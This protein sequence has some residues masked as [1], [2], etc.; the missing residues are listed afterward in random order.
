MLEAVAGLLLLLLVLVEL[1][2]WRARQR[3]AGW[4]VLLPAA[5]LVAESRG[6]RRVVQRLA[7]PL[8]RLRA[9]QPAVRQALQRAVQP[10]LQPAARQALQPAVQPA[11]RQALQPAARQALQQ[12][13]R[14]GYLWFAV[15]VSPTILSSV[16]GQVVRLWIA[17]Q[18]RYVLRIVTVPVPRM[19]AVIRY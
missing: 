11:V 19:F 1:P 2:V 17:A 13:V 6:R 14:E 5:P 3:V 18:A 8:A 9:L 7:A 10:A 4:L 15:T 16:I 12:A